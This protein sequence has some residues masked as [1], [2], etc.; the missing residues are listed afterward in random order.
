MA[1][2]CPEDRSAARRHSGS[3]TIAEA[4]VDKTVVAFRSEPAPP[5]DHDRLSGATTLKTMKSRERYRP[6]GKP[7]GNKII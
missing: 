5:F 6:F 4:G 7:S 1:E 3:P 2:L